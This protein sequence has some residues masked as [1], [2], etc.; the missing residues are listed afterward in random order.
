MTDV[1]LPLSRL[2][3]PLVHHGRHFGRTIHAL[4]RVHS[5]LTKGLMRE[6]DP[7]YD[8]EETLTAE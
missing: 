3:D 5:L 7:G 8:S 1:Q 6:T 4:C 2:S